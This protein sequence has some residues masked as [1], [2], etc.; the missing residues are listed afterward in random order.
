MRRA[1]RSLSARNRKLIPRSG[2]GERMYSDIKSIPGSEANTLST[3]GRYSW[4]R[5]LEL[6]L[7]QR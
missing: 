7:L 2:I 6:Y 1:L 4:T 3:Y 5:V